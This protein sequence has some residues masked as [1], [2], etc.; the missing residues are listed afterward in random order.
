[1]ARV[2]G[3]LLLYGASTDLVYDCRA[4]VSVL[5]PSA[6]PLARACSATPS[7]ASGHAVA[8][9]TLALLRGGERCALFSSAVLRHAKRVFLALNSS[10][11][12]AVAALPELR[13]RE[14]ALCDA[15]Q[16]SGELAARRAE[17]LAPLAAAGR[18]RQPQAVAHISVDDANRNQF[19]ERAEQATYNNR[20]RQRD[21]FL[22]IQRVWLESVPNDVGAD[23]AALLELRQLAVD[24]LGSGVR[25]FLAR[26]DSLNL[27]WLAAMLRDQ[28][29][30]AAVADPLDEQDEAI[31]SIA[32]AEK[33]RKLRG[34]I[35]G[36][37][38]AT[39]ATSAPSG[40]A[41]RGKSTAHGAPQQRVRMPAA[42]AAVVAARQRSFAAQFVGANAAAARATAA[43][44]FVYEF[45]EAA[46]QQGGH[47]HTALVCVLVGSLRDMLRSTGA[48][49]APSRH[50]LAALRA[51]FA[52]QTQQLCALARFLGFVQ[53]LP[54]FSVYPQA[55]DAPLDGVDAVDAMAWPV[56]PAAYVAAAE[57]NGALALTLPWVC[58][59]LLAWRSERAMLHSQLVRQTVAALRS[60]APSSV[61]LCDNLSSPLSLPRVFALHTLT[62]TLAAIG[63]PPDVPRC[64]P[65]AAAAP[66][67]REVSALR[68][69]AALDDE[70]VTT[71]P[72]KRLLSLSSLDGGAAP[73]DFA[74][75]LDDDFVRLCFEP[76]DALVLA[77][78][79]LARD[80]GGGGGGG[81]G[82]GPTKKITLTNYVAPAP[83]SAVGVA[84]RSAAAVSQSERAQEQLRRWF[85]WQHP[86]LAALA[87]SI[88]SSVAR[89]AVAFISENNGV[90]RGEIESTLAQLLARVAWGDAAARLQFERLA[91]EP[92]AAVLP[93]EVAALQ[94]R[95]SSWARD[96]VTAFVTERVGAVLP[97]LLP[98]T[99][100]AAVTSAAVAHT[101]GMALSLVLSSG[102][103]RAAH[104]VVNAVSSE[105]GKLARACRHDAL[106]QWSEAAPTTEAAIQCL[107]AATLLFEPRDAECTR[108]LRATTSVNPQLC[109]RVRE[110][111]RVDDDA[112][113]GGGGGGAEER[114]GVALRCV[115]AAIDALLFTLD[116]EPRRRE[117]QQ[118]QPLLP[119]AT[120]A[121]GE[122]AAHALQHASGA[123]QATAVCALVRRA[124]ASVAA[125]DAR[126]V[127]NVVQL[128]RASRHVGGRSGEVQRVVGAFLS[129]MQ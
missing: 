97:L 90:L 36:A 87:E 65:R 20:E 94:A 128:L 101:R 25:Q 40:G 13:K 4:V 43:L 96:A 18:R 109:A 108:V 35:D 46:L 3:T 45:A 29:L 89:A 75:L 112:V 41:L 19:R 66:P 54:F 9:W 77:A 44:A 2:F 17:I 104:I 15:L 59:L 51:T 48:D 56:Q 49:G 34:R 63:E 33:L 12:L 42:T 113:G 7:D 119:R 92:L 21:E 30:A 53:A 23:D 38:G 88:S 61:L 84:Q 83:S 32:S 121:L 67:P 124:C 122:A 98:A 50:D 105:L 62:T 102:A 126:A 120:L 24:E 118:W 70:P 64:A 79:R 68:A 103:Q 52:R 22:M 110:L 82:G 1:M 10:A 5:R 117:R 115:A 16:K 123:A 111:A 107:Y 71:T 125:I 80:D 127:R 11:Q 8:L 86:Q 55:S 60:V 39:G 99:L 69:S 58:A 114:S 85:A 72:E 78:V 116:A 100:S 6:P 129:E 26:T 47:L 28:L 93:S 27:P 31:K 95:V 14:P 57:R 76:L 91:R 81:G 106:P 37:R 73:D 74:E